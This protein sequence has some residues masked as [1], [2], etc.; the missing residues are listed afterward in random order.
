MINDETE[1][2][3][4][5][6]RSNIAEDT[7]RNPVNHDVTSC[8]EPL[9]NEQSQKY[10]RDTDAAKETPGAYHTDRIQVRSIRTQDDVDK[11]TTN[12]TGEIVPNVGSR[13]IQFTSTEELHE[14]FPI[15]SANLLKIWRSNNER[16]PQPSCSRKSK[17]SNDSNETALDKVPANVVGTNIDQD[18]HVNFT[19]H[20]V[21]S[22]N[23]DQNIGVQRRASSDYLNSKLLD[24]NLKLL[25]SQCE[26]NQINKPFDCSNR[27]LEIKKLYGETIQTDTEVGNTSSANS[28]GSKSSTPSISFRESFTNLIQGC[29]YFENKRLIPSAFKKTDIN[30]SRNQPGAFIDELNSSDTSCDGKEKVQTSGEPVQTV[31]KLCKKTR[32]VNQNYLVNTQQYV[33]EFKISIGEQGEQISNKSFTNERNSISESNTNIHGTTE[34]LFLKNNLIIGIENKTDAAHSAHSN[35]NE[36]DLNTDAVHGRDALDETLNESIDKRNVFNSTEQA[37]ALDTSDANPDTQLDEASGADFNVSPADLL[38]SLQLSQSSEELHESVGDRPDCLFHL[39]NDGSQGCYN[40]RLRV[41]LP[42][43]NKGK[44]LSNFNAGLCWVIVVYFKN[45]C[46]KIRYSKE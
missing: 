29:N 21:R 9:S 45:L 37:T 26:E 16:N 3:H 2:V 8:N 22:L 32:A 19:E 13:H 11:D 36:D 42:A 33:D 34:N 20:L 7:A 25:K 27:L 18:N 24:N 28:K 41:M 43:L 44:K 14:R 10:E 39:T 12:L 38:R 5:V 1:H 30:D 17:S 4:S 40:I 15:Y 6:T 31:N 23:E 35:S 46:I